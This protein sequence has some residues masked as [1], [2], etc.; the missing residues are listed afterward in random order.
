MKST[1]Q[2][3]QG[4]IKEADDGDYV[5]HDDYSDLLAQRDMAVELL[6]TALSYWKNYAKGARPIL[7]EADVEHYVIADIDNFLNPSDHEPEQ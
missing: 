6:R 2:I 4:C 7:A 5:S 1:S 3:E